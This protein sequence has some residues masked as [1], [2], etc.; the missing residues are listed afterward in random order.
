MSACQSLV[1]VNFL[2]ASNDQDLLPEY[3]LEERIHR[4]QSV[5][6]ALHPR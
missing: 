6:E 4:G 3:G 5:A 2:I 1:P